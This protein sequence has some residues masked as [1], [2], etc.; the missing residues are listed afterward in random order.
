VVA[1]EE[2]KAKLTHLRLSTKSATYSE[3]GGIYAQFLPGFKLS[4]F[5]EE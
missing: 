3:K 4:Y 2:Q 5:V 1:P